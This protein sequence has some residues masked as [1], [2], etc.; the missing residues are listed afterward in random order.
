MERKIT[1]LAPFFEDPYRSFHI[2]ELARI[3]KINHTTVRQYLQKLVREDILKTEKGRIF[4]IYNSNQS[5]KYL[6]LKL[7]YNLE[8]IRKSGITETLEKEFDYPTIILFGSYAKAIDDTKSDVDLCIVSEIRKEF[9][10]SQYEKIINREITIHYFTKKQWG[11]AKIKNKEL[12]NGI[13]NG[14]VLS[15]ELKVL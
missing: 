7:F 1:I 13:C 12:I 11:N 6:N 15:G 14:I 9:D 3:L 2:R 8:K 10:T 4:V 5:R